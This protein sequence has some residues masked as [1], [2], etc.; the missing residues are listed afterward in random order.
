MFKQL[1][2]LLRVGVS[3]C[4]QHQLLTDEEKDKYFVSGTYDMTMTYRHGYMSCDVYV[5]NDVLKNVNEEH[6]NIHISPFVCMH[7]LCCDTNYHLMVR[8]VSSMVAAHLMRLIL[9]VCCLQTLCNNYDIAT[10]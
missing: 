1:Q 2:Q 5:S 4:V 9:I 7:H 6:V 10:Y 8:L 3:I